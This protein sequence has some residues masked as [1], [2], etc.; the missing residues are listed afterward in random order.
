MRKLVV[1]ADP[2]GSPPPA[3]GIFAVAEGFKSVAEGFKSVAEASEA[4][5]PR[6]L[7]D[8]RGAFGIAFG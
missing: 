8:A 7:R 5:F 4:S 3:E 6:V 1:V 2:Q